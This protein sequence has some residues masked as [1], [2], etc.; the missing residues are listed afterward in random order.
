MGDWI[1]NIKGRSIEQDFT[2]IMEALVDD[3]QALGH[4]ISS[5]R[6]T[7]DAGEKNIT[8]GSVSEPTPDVPVTPAPAPTIPTPVVETPAPVV[9][10][11]PPPAVEVPAPVV[12]VSTPAPVDPTPP[13]T[14]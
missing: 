1:L 9:E 8:P 6:L 5:V 12:D 4:R 14:S 11:P 13:A 10:A 7:S 2:D 3:L